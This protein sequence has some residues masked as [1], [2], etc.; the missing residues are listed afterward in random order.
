MT[1][2]SP[3]VDLP[4]HWTALR[5]ELLPVIEDVLSRG[6][7]IMRDELERFESSI[8]ELCGSRFA[9]GLNSCTDGMVIALR[10]AGVGPGDEVITVAHTFVATVAAIVHNSATP[11][12]VD[13][14][15][16]DQ[17]MSVEALEA[18]I[19]P[20]TKAIIPVHL[21]GRICD[22][23]RIMELAE[24]HDLV[25]VEDAAQALGATLDGT[26]AGAFGI[27]GSFSLYPMKLLGAYGDGGVLVTDDENLYQMARML[28]D[29]GQNRTTGEVVTYGYNSR[30]DNLQ[31]AILE[32][33]LRHFPDWLEHRRHIASLYDEGLSD[34]SEV[35]V[36]PRQTDDRR[37]DVYQ[38]YVIRAARRDE[39]A[40]HL[41]EAGV[42][43]L[44]SWPVPM[45]HHAGL[46]LGGFDLPNT[47]EISRTVLSL[48]MNAEVTEE[49]VAYTIDSV[50]SFYE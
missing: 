8:A 29:H 25:V 39:L 23:G 35:T 17:L 3:F 34:L 18:A 43:V 15:L 31:A 12:L 14:E 27:S 21:N 38:N 33:K 5:D 42:E 22:M 48:P 45:H 26:K 1:Y 13:V 47:E 32:V 20:A 37:Y 50:R 28:R 6:Q 19:T 44:V 10:A 11:V 2:K 7:V 40:K 4:S 49:Q 30:L 9:V 24:A 46:G 36:P 16:E 41:G